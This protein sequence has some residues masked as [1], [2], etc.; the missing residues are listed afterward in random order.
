MDIKRIDENTLIIEKGFKQEMKTDA[1]IYADKEI[2]NFIEKEALN[3]I[4]NV[5]TLPGIVGKAYA[6]PDIHKGYGFPI[7]GIAAFDVESGI[8]SPGG[9]GY[10]IN[11]G[12]RLLK[13]NL[14]L[15][16][17]E[18]KKK[19]LTLA[20][21]KNIPLGVGSEG[22]IHLTDSDWKELIR[23]GAGWAVEKGYG[24]ED[25]LEFIESNGKIFA[26]GYGISKKAYDR[27]RDQLGT[28]G[29]GNHFLEVSFVDEIYDEEKAKVFELEKNMIC[30]MIHTG[31]R[32]FGHQIATDYTSLMVKVSQKYGIKLHDKE[33]ACAPFN[34]EEGRRYFDAMSA[35]AN[36]AW[37]NRQILKHFTQKA[38]MNALSISKNELGIKTIYDVAHNIAKI[39]QHIVNGKMKKVIVHRKGATRA[40][41]KNMSDIPKKYID[42]GQPII[43]PGD[44]GRYSY[45]LVGLPSAM[46]KS[47][48]STCHGAGRVLSRTKAI[49]NSKNRD[50]KSEL[51]KKGIIVM[52]NSKVTLEEEISEAYKDVTK[53]VKVVE[54]VGISSKVVRFKP[55]CVVKG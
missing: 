23:K 9:I 34:S 4:I 26:E 16:D 47:F 17:V 31:S 45:L 52:A 44:M 41:P 18:K 6:M 20:L 1:V 43:I 7:G 19:E 2:E 49:E 13:T 30:I 29:S 8:I 25:D 28:L 36:F 51:E 53:V 15:F 5:T 38:I 14:K 40:F 32:G 3:Q 22:P 55:I 10:D 39:E 27:G 42:V 35:A 54:S 11:C 48:G 21:Y 46:D 37:A 12:V 33:L 50:I 24:E